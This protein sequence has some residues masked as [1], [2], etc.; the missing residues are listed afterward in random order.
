MWVS[1][2]LRVW[3]N[4]KFSPTEKN[5]RQVNYLVISLVKMLLA[6]NFCQKRVRENFRSVHTV[7]LTSSRA[8]VPQNFQIHF[9]LEPMGQFYQNQCLM[10][11]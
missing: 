4:E 9:S 8:N 10:I 3:K 7:C 5:I 6:R 11:A 2:F 1:K